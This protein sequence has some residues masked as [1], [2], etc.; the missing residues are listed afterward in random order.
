MSYKNGEKSR[1]YAVSTGIGFDAA[2]CH[3]AVIS[4]MKVFLNKIHLGKLT[5]L[6]IALSR[7]IALRPGKMR[8]RLDDGEWIEYDRAYFAT[9]MNHPF[10]GGGFKFCP[11]ADPC[12]DILNV[13]VISGL[14]KW[15]VLCLLPTAFKGWHIRFRGID[16][17][18]CKK[19]EI[20]S[21]QALPVH[22]DGEPVFL[23]RKMTAALEPD[24]IRL[25]VG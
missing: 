23:Q 7:M 5:Y 17:Y 9:A 6:G 14:P 10:E 1:R 22:T 2:V 20:D 18:T 4:K 24:K 21:E 19:V 16:T 3:Q 25:I 8:V 12:D 11:D 13:T 15:K